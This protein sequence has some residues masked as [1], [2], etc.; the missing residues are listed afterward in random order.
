MSEDAV[1]TLSLIALVWLGWPLHS[2][3]SDFRALR[4]MADKKP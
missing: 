3:A 1:I 4:K 2:I